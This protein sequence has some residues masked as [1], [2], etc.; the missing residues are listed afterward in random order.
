MTAHTHT[1]SRFSTRAEDAHWQLRRVHIEDLV[2]P[3][4]LQNEGPSMRGTKELVSETST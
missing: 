3:N 4:R 2:E 1:R